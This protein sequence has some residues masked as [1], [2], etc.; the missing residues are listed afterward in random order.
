MH[1]LIALRTKIRECLNPYLAPIRRFRAGLNNSNSLSII[2]NNCWGGH[3][4]RF[5]GLP[6][7][8]PTI[9]L[10]FF[11]DEYI[12]F[13][14]DIEHY[15]SVELEFIPLEQSKYCQILKERNTPPCPIGVLDDVELVFLHYHSEDE[16]Q[17]KWTRRKARLDMNHLIV[18]MTEQ[19]LCSLEHL[20]SFDALPFDTKFVLVHKDYGLQSQ[21]ICE[22]FAKDT[23]VLNDTDEFRRH[24]NLISLVRGKK[25]KK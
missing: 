3:V 19:N 9:G 12:K 23:E 24:I 4:Y 18:K 21:I 25:Y 7:S 1:F 16:A 20:K 15:L 6:Y 2:S 5:F 10:Y 17:E 8:S 11:T 22:E 13:L 14:K